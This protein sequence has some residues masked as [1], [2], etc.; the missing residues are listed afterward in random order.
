[1]TR[2]ASAPWRPHDPSESEPTS[3][4]PA[5]WPTLALIVFVAVL[6]L[7]WVTV[8]SA[9]GGFIKPFHLAAFVFIGLCLLRWRPG[10][11][12]G[13]AWRRHWAVYGAYTFLLCVVFAGGLAYR[14]PFLSRVIVMRQAYYLAVALVITGFI[15]LVIGRRAQLWLAASGAAASLVLSMGFSLALAKQHANPFSI[16]R[17]AVAQS[18][19]DIITYQLLRSAFRTDED[20]AEVAANLRHKVFVGLLVAVLLGLAC[21]KI[22]EQRQRFLRVLSAVAGAIGFALVTLSLSRSTILCMLVPLALFPL[23]LIVRNRARPAQ[24]LGLALAVATA[25]A[26]LISPVGELLYARFTATGS[27]ESRITA[28]GPSFLEDFEGA[29][30]AGAPKAAVEKSPHNFVLHSWLSGG[31]LA[32][33]A[34]TVMLLSVAKVWLVEAKRYLLDGPGWVIPVEQIWVLGLGVIPLIRAF[35]SGSQFH[36]V[37]WTAIALFLGLTFANERA[38]ARDQPSVASAVLNRS[39]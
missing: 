9:G 36:M 3:A 25:L 21:S 2:L 26:L 37:E 24:A 35:T 27:Y 39:R 4:T 7:E 13:P 19:P 23:R 15:V 28:A 34:A 30:F 33:A 38:A 6:P 5:R 10:V 8:T 31:V 16:V 18:N 32:A 12:L 11:L 17:D 29:A 22:L 14:D 20:L 1:M